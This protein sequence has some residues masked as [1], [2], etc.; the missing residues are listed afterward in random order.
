MEGDKKKG[1]RKRERERE[2]SS[3]SCVAFQVISCSVQRR[4]S[5]HNKHSNLTPIYD[6]QPLLKAAVLQFPNMLIY[7]VSETIKQ[8]MEKLLNAFVDSAFEFFDQLLQSQVICWPWVSHLP[9]C[10]D[11]KQHNL[12]LIFCM[13]KSA[14][15]IIYILIDA[16]TL[17][18]GVKD[19]LFFFFW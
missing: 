19:R 2:M 11:L 17:S 13:S 1:K 14:H 5:I 16:Y 10:N 18:V 3:L 12:C 4:L 9:P 7:Q 8:S 15:T 6:I